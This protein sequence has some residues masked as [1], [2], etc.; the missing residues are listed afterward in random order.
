MTLR[1]ITCKKCA[2]TNLRTLKVL[3]P[4]TIKA[5]VQA[6]LKCSDCGEEAEYWIPSQHTEK[7]MRQ[8]FI[9]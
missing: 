6:T 4:D 3:D 2:S 8:G 1:Q 7:M 9:I 5:S